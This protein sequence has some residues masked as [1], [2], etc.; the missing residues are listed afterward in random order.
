M[1]SAPLSSIM[2][3][4]QMKKYYFES[5]RLSFFSLSPLSLSFFDFLSL[6]FLWDFFLVAGLG[7]PSDATHSLELRG[8]A[9]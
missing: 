1:F 4:C 3:R 9:S 2:S 8:V 7:V 5:L 6:S